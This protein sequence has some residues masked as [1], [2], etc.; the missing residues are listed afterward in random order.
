[1]KETLVYIRRENLHIQL[2][3]RQLQMW[4]VKP[5]NLTDS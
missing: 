5:R 1:M 2:V 4:S 3:I